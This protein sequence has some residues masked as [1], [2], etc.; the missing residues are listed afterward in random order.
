M[1]AGKLRKRIEIQRRSTTRDSYGQPTTAWETLATT[2]AEIEPMSGRELVA[3]MAVQSEV[4]HTVTIRYRP[5]I[6]ATLR[7]KYAD[8]LFNIHS[9]IDESERHR[10]LTLMCSEGMN[11]G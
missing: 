4:T 9:V 10:M 11:D 2:Q 8:R 5:G 3:A 1:Q 6:N 7:I